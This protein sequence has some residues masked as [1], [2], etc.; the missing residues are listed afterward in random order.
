MKRS[1][2]IISYK[3]L[4]SEAKTSDNIEKMDA[5]LEKTVSFGSLQNKDGN[6]PK[7]MNPRT[8]RKQKTIKKRKLKKSNKRL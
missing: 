8:V 2:E 4:F 5:E 6:Y 3:S 7:W 1:K